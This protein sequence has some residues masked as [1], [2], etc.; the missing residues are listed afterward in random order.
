MAIKRDGGPNM[1]D[2]SSTYGV[3]M[4]IFHIHRQLVHL[5]VFIHFFL[6]FVYFVAMV[7]LESIFAISAFSMGVLAHPTIKHADR[8]FCALE[9][10]S[11]FGRKELTTR[12]T[13]P[14]ATTWNPPSN[15]V[16]ALDQVSRA[17]VMAVNLC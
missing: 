13:I 5:F 11:V 15:M 7:K 17:R 4:A 3:L 12:A 14:K 9:E 2:L 1:K 8:R 10:T 6:S 16:T